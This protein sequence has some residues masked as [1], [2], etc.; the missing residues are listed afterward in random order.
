VKF[1]YRYEKNP[2]FIWVKFMYR[3]EKNPPFI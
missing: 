1:M 2:P 3:Y